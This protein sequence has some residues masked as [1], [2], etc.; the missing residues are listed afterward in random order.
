MRT[1]KLL[2]FI[3]LIA[4]IL[5]NPKV[6]EKGHEVAASSW[7]KGYSNLLSLLLFRSYLVFS[8]SVEVNNFDI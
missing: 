6:L 4:S 8:F 7:A 3:H 1:A 5:L 2:N